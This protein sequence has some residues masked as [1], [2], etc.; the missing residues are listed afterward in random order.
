ML[1]NRLF[2]ILNIS[3]KIEP[4]VLKII[5]SVKIILAAIIAILIAR[6]LKLDYAIAAGIVAI[7]SVQPTKRETLKTGLSRFYAF[8][9]ALVISY[10]CYHLI[11]FTTLAFFIYVILFIFICQ[12]FGWHSAMAMD[13]VLISHFINF[14]RMGFIEIKNE[15]FLFIIGVGMGVIAN[16]T[17]RKKVSY[18][19][20]LKTEADDLI[21]QTLCGMSKRILDINFVDDDEKCFEKL[22]A[23][24]TQA[25]V[26]AAENYNNQFCKKDVYD[27][28]YIAMRKEQKEVLIEI[29]KCI[30]ELKTVPKTANLV[31]EFLKK[32]SV[33]YEKNND[34]EELLKELHSIQNMMKEKPLP[35]ERLEFEDRAILFMILKR[36]EEF[37]GIK[38]RFMKNLLQ[39]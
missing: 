27:L 20:R 39:L 4:M 35:V 11:G 5:N 1:T 34:V 7:L 28:E 32:V 24:I 21:R 31:S 12:I 38:N 3:I 36:T 17:L 2:F 9:I 15:V 29:F 19:E 8:V 16:L 30:V 14:G 6:L 22:D 25:E 13:S 23:A 26:I 18:I 10:F 33:E 37:L